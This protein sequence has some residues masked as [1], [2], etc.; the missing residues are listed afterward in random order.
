MRCCWST[1]AT[2]PRPTTS[3]RWSKQT[4]PLHPALAGALPRAEPED[5]RLFDLLKRAYIEA[6]YSPGYRITQDELRAL[7]DRVP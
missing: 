7:Q 4:A 2:N 1:P 3:R 6:R 5:Q